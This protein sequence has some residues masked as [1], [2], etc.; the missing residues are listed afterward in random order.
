MF[1][2]IR[3]L[4]SPTGARLAYR[5]EPARGAGK[6]VVLV[7]HGLAEHSRRYRAFAERLA[8]SGFHVYAHDHRGHGETTAPDAP[9]GRFAPSRRLA[10]R[11]GGH[12]G[13]TRTGQPPTIRGCPIVLFGHS[14]GG[15]LALGFAETHPD[16]I[17]GLAVWNSNLKPGIAGRAAQALLLAERM[18]KGSDVPSTLLPQTHLRRLG[19]G[20]PGPANG[21][22]LALARS[23]GG[24]RIYR[25]SALRLRCQ[26]LALARR[27]RADLC[28]RKCR[29]DRP[30]APNACRSISSAATRIRR[31]TSA[32]RSL[33]RQAAAG[34]GDWS[35]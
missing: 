6:G 27:F 12:A 18:L 21:L 13:D 16:K 26:R 30:P 10:H 22:R 14:M 1:C 8:A 7:S 34:C 15:L 5:H 28:G 35:T 9:I 20:D 23:R 4:Q 24:R 32:A 25:R 29:R 3:H 31:P 33:A 19:E 17:D 2:T 11:A